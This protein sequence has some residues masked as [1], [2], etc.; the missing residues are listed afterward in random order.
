MIKLVLGEYTHAEDYSDN[1]LRVRAERGYLQVV[2]SFR[3]YID[4]AA[5]GLTLD[6]YERGE[7][8]EAD[9]IAAILGDIP[10]KIIK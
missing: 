1:V 6:L 10:L 8:S 3:T 9:R 7:A 2:N 4:I 5:P